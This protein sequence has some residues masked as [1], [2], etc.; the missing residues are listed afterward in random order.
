MRGMRIRNET[1]VTEV[2]KVSQ[3]RVLVEGAEN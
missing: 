2:R 3:L 1:N